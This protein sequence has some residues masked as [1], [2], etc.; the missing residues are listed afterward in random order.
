MLKQN[1]DYLLK[2]A[3]PWVVYRTLTDLFGL[4]ANYPKVITVKAQLLKYPLMQGLFEELEGLAGYCFKQS[5]KRRAALPQTGISSGPGI[6][7][8]RC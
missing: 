2:A 4:K 5:Q 8:R 7:Q 6:N 3:E 1:T